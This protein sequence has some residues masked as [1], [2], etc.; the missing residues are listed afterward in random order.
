MLKIKIGIWNLA[1]F[2]TVLALACMSKALG[3]ILALHILRI[4][5][6]VCNSSTWEV[7]T[8]R[9]EVQGPS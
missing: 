1:Q 7:T 2:G 4:V 6:H 8:G 3:S 5:V 9:S